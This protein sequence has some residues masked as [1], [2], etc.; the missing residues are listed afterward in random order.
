MCDQQY[1]RRIETLLVSRDVEILSLKAQILELE[2]R[3]SMMRKVGMELD[4]ERRRSK[5][6]S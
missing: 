3:L 5:S 6:D 2:D 1:V 4:D